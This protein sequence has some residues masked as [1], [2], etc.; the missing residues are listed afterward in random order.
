MSNE[1]F[2][3]DTD[4]RVFHKDDDLSDEKIYEDLLKGYEHFSQVIKVKLQLKEIKNIT[5]ISPLFINIK[6]LI[7]FYKQIKRGPVRASRKRKRD[8]AIKKIFE[9]YSVR[10]K[11]LQKFIRNAKDRLKYTSISKV[12][13][14]L[15]GI[16]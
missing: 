3:W 14:S 10:I 8:E 13:L 1:V 5:K 11:T 9:L 12:V 2:D 7:E 4:R 16:V 15:Q 6:T